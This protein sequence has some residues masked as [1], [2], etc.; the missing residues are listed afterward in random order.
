MSFG[1]E[2]LKKYFGVLI[3]KYDLLRTVITTLSMA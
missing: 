1:S 3:M 2:E